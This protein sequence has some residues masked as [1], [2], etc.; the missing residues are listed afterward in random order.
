[1][2]S[3]KSFE[4]A[5]V[6]DGEGEEITMCTIEERDTFDK[7]DVHCKVV[8]VKELAA[9]GVHESRIKQDDHTHTVLLITTIAPQLGHCLT[10]FGEPNP[11]PKPWS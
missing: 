10:G 1:M 4:D 7:V 3:T 11:P 2:E 5:G 9:V 8:K 6:V